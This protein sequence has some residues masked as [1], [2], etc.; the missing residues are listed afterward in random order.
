VALEVAFLEFVGGVLDAAP[1]C[2]EVNRNDRS[3]RCAMWLGLGSS[4]LS[5]GGRVESVP[6]LGGR[7]FTLFGLGKLASL[8]SR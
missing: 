3:E 7:E 2:I 8:T 4:F 5:L 1:A 6:E